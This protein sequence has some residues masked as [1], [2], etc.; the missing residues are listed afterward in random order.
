MLLLVF[1]LSDVDGDR[2][3]GTVQVFIYRTHLAGRV[4]GVADDGDRLGTQDAKINT[5]LIRTI[6][7]IIYVV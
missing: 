3:H 2:D 5:V 6:T 1:A 4:G 7:S